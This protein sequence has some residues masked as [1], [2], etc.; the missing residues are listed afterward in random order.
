MSPSAILDRSSS[1]FEFVAFKNLKVEHDGPTP[2][3]APFLFVVKTPD[4]TTLS[5]STTRSAAASINSHAQ[6]WAQE[7]AN[8][9]AC[10]NVS[11]ARQTEKLV[12]QDCMTRCR[13]SRLLDEPKKQQRPKKE[14]RS[15][16]RRQSSQASAKQAKEPKSKVSSIVQSETD[17][18]PSP[19]V[20]SVCSSYPLEEDSPLLQTSSIL[21]KSKLHPSPFTATDCFDSRCIPIDRNVHAILEYYIAFALVST[22]ST[23]LQQPSPKDT[24][25]VQKVAYVNAIIQ[26]CLEN[27]LHMY[28]LLAATASRMRKISRIATA[29]DQ[30]CQFYLQKALQSLRMVLDADGEAVTKNSQTIFDIYMLSVCGWYS[31]SHA[32]SRVHFDVL[33]HVW[34]SLVPER[35]ILD[36]LLHEFLS[37]NQIYVEIDV[38]SPS[39]SD[40]EESRVLDKIQPSCLTK[41]TGE[42]CCT[43]LSS[44]LEQMFCS[45][46]LKALVP[47]LA[48][49]LRVY[50]HLTR[51]QT[52]SDNVE[53]D[54]VLSKSR[55]LVV[56]L[57]DFPAY[58]AE[59]CCRISLAL[60]LRHILDSWTRSCS[61]SAT[62]MRFDL[63]LLVKRLRQRLQYEILLPSNKIDPAAFLNQDKESAAQET[64]AGIWTG[65]SNHLL[66]WVLISGLFGARLTR[67]QAEYEW[68][69]LRAEP[70]LHILG[71][72]TMSEL[73]QEMTRF[74]FVEDMLDDP[75][76]RQI[77]I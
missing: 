39:A 42:R 76:L 37:Y 73:R 7:Y 10:K 60:L 9:E 61:P 51:L 69:W 2:T 14:K 16:A 59:E 34:N 11:S 15:S 23:S 12:F 53:K 20:E 58:G 50:P 8:S 28:S 19:D 47:E 3:R 44:A 18:S 36:C 43:A 70:L 49:V 45:S 6:Q 5:R 67:E 13:V 4:S 29:T 77:L 22:S 74:V 21:P 31:E 54:W 56:R 57:L 17:S 52:D 48:Q 25:T 55:S 66:L 38:N 72:Q 63:A 41:T 33:K 68:F 32:E 27:H 40:A 35:S 75:R 46:D 30:L 64:Q 1:Q 24:P 65:N 62:T 26:G 71:V